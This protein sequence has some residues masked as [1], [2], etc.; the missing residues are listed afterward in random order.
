MFADDTSIISPVRDPCT[1]FNA[2]NNDMQQ[3]NDWALQWKM[4]FNP[5]PKKQA[6]EVLFSR[7][8]TGNDNDT[9]T[10]KNSPVDIV[11]SKKHLGL[12]LDE[13]LYFKSHV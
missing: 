13:K 12:I 10:F 6:N 1:T 2:L 4:R 9:L 11:E 5:D 7:K 8:I 3:I